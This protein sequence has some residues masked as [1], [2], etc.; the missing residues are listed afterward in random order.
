[1][2]IFFDG[3]GHGPESL[4]QVSAYYKLFPGLHVFCRIS[5]GLVELVASE[6]AST[7]SLFHQSP[8][9]FKKI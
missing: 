7:S 8:S 6:F 5:A 4:C 2:G 9:S 3:L 1:M